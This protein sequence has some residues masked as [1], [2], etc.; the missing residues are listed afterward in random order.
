V[1]EGESS[2]NQ[3]A[4]T[5]ESIPVDKG[6]GSFVYAGSINENGSQSVKVTKLIEDTTISKFARIY[7]PIVFILA[8]LVII[9]PPLF[10][11]GTWEDWIYKGLMLLVIAC[12]INSSCDCYCPWKC[13]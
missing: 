4:I 12:Y 3:A 8:L 13:R 5:G 2:V 7:T 11:F 10:A 9:L 1:I 6:K